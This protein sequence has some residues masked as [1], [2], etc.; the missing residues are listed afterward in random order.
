MTIELILKIVAA[1]FVI[2]V[3]VA[4]LVVVVEMLRQVVRAVKT[5]EIRKTIMPL[6]AMFSIVAGFAFLVVLA[7]LHQEAFKIFNDQLVSA[8]KELM[9]GGNK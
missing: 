3:L 7:F 1:V 6:V 8:L 4:T 9:N 2:A 5:G